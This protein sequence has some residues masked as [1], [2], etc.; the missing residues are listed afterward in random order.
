MKKVSL[1]WEAGENLA[2]T[3]QIK[4]THEIM[5]FVKTYF[6]NA[7]NTA[8]CPL[9]YLGSERFLADE[10]Y[11]QRVSFPVGHH[12]SFFFAH[13]LRLLYWSRWTSFRYRFSHSKQSKTRK[14]FGK[15]WPWNLVELPPRKIWKADLSGVSSSSERKLTLACITW[16]K[17]HRLFH[18]QSV[19][20]SWG[21]S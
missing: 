4:I 17:E 1:V 6:F 5:I 18:N 20:E 2:L 12:Y 9:S 16:S 14:V 8:K 21:P 15:C 7:L 19:S 10:I 13:S 11:W 3:V